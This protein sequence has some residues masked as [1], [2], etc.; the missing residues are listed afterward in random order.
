MIVMFVGGPL[1]G[2]V[3]DIDDDRLSDG[4]VILVPV[5]ANE[6][7]PRIRR[8]GWMLEYLYDEGQRTARYVAGLVPGSE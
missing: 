6:E 5:M 4:S 3:R 2:D 8:D 7:D 1:D